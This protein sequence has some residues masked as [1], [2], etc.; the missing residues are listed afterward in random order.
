MA[1]IITT[2]GAPATVIINDLGART[3]VHP[4]VSYDLETGYTPFELSQSADLQAAITGGEITAVDGSG[5]PITIV[6]QLTD[7]QAAYNSS[8]NPEIVT[9]ATLG[10]VTIKRG[11]AADTNNVLETK[12]GAGSN[13][14]EVTGAGKVTGTDFND[15]ALT[16][17]GVATNYLD[18]TGAYSAPASG[19]VTSVTGSTPIASSGGATPDISISAATTS[20]AG[21]M[22][23]ADKT[24]LDGIAAGAQPGTVTAVTGTTPIASSGG[25]APAIS[26]TAATTIAAGSMS[27]ADKT[28]LDGIAAGAQPGTITAITVTLPL[29]TTGGTTPLLNI[30]PAT[31]SLPGVMSSA[32]KTKLDGLGLDPILV[33]DTGSEPNFNSSGSPPTDIPD[34]TYTI[35]VDGSYLLMTSIDFD[36]D[37]SQRTFDIF[38]AINGTVE[39]NSNVQNEQRHSTNNT[40]ISASWVNDGLESLVNGDV[41]TIQGATQS[42]NMDLFHRRMILIK[43]KN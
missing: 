25:T 38:F 6:G 19:G 13:T 8:M 37:T 24:K 18:E 15:V 35:V 14:F 30:N 41:I 16:T 33:Q 20:V 34:L 12:N 9:D 36:P 26:I 10:A 3:F 28:K 22:S 21:S 43:L 39:P 32:D 17:G 7:L 5:N 31:V 42:S 27:A 4:V 2:T 11:S 29:T 23:G 1:F 40:F